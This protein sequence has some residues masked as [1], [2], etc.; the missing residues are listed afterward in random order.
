MNRKWGGWPC[1]SRIFSDRLKNNDEGG[2]EFLVASIFRF[3]FFVIA[4]FLLF[5]FPLRISHWFEAPISERRKFEKTSVFRSNLAKL[6]RE[7]LCRERR[8]WK[9]KK[10][11]E[12]Y[13]IFFNSNNRKLLHRGVLYWTQ[14][15][16]TMWGGRRKW[17]GSGCLDMAPAGKTN[18][19]FAPWSTAHP[20]LPPF[21]SNSSPRLGETPKIDREIYSNVSLGIPLLYR[22]IPNG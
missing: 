19:S 8:A 1:V 5:F 15:G 7:I 13:W 9:M 14:T 17:I 16:R 21:R 6:R 11:R 20:L 12:I 18:R 22:N 3:R 4:S 10:R 2:I